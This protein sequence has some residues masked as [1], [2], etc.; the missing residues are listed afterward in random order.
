MFPSRAPGAELEQE[1]AT[2][3]LPQTLS[4]TARDSVSRRKRMFSPQRPAAAVTINL[5]TATIR[6][7]P[8][9]G[10]SSATFREPLPLVACQAGV[11]RVKGVCMF[12]T[13]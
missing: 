12:S 5:W 10:V 6:R 13:S 8:A 7:P 3:R 1:R 11:S 9:P 4:K 2:P